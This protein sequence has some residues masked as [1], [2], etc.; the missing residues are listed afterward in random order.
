MGGVGGVGG[1]PTKY[2]IIKVKY[3]KKI[4]GEP[5]TPPIASHSLLPLYT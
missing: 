4:G 2:S 1:S 5:P 3:K